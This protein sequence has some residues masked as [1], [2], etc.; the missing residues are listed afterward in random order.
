MLSAALQ[1][2]GAALQ[3]IA[4]LGSSMAQ[5]QTRYFGPGG[6]SLFQ[7]KGSELQY[8]VCSL[9]ACVQSIVQTMPMVLR[10]ALLN[11]HNMRQDKVQTNGRIMS[12]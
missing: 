7:F 6:G 4:L 10:R 3:L 12:K 11:I 5:L 2:Y 1:T 8:A 9:R